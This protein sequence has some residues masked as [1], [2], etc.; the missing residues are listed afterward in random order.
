MAHLI[1][2]MAYKGQTPW[3]ELGTKIHPEASIEAWINAAGLSW[4]AKELPVYLE[5]GVQVP[6][7]KALVRSDTGK[8]LSI[9]S[10]RYK[11]VQP[12][13]ILEFYR[14]LTEDLGYALETAG[15]LKGGKKIWALAKTT[16][17]LTLPGNDKVEGYF[18][19]ATSLD[20]TLSTVAKPTSIRVVCNNTLHISLGENTKEI[21]VGHKSKFNP[22][23]VK[24]A[25]GL[26]SNSW[27]VF[28]EVAN[29]LASRKVSAAE[30]TDF[31][32]QV[33][34]KT[35]DPKKLEKG[36]Q[37]QKGQ[38]IIQAIKHSPGSNLPSAQGTAWGLLNGLTNWLD[39][40]ASRNLDNRL[41]SS[42]FGQGA[43]IKQNAVDFLAGLRVDNTQVAQQEAS[44]D[45]FRSL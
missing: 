32:G 27:G 11:P 18:L 8:A 41:N 14:D 35:D 10:E 29:V 40:T 42:W 44:Q 33:V 9:M 23:K 20:G 13:E 45:F 38:Q 37:S 6:G 25:L 34:F 19:L 22:Q 39:Y 31:F 24:E 5:G 26:V 2:S 12:R 30:V 3:H 16:D 21:R 36:L 4:H 7:Y 43:E 28:A 1:D 15:S 17:T